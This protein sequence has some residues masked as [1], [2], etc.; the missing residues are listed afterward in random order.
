MSSP[1][2]SVCMP[3]SRPSAMFDEALSSVLAQTLGDFEVVVTDD[4]GGSLRATIEDAND[5]RVRYHPNA[6]R[7]GLSGNHCKAIDSARGRFVAIL[8][9]DDAWLPT[10][11]ET[12]ADVLQRG[13]QVGLCISASVDVAADGTVLRRKPNAMVPGVQRDPL[14]HLLDPR[15]PVMHPSATVWRRDALD[16]NHRP[17]ADLVVAD[18]TAFIDPVLAG[19]QVHYS[20]VPLVRYR[21]HDGQIGATQQCR[22]RDGLVKLWSGY[23]FADSRHEQLRR[24]LLARWHIARAGA[25]LRSGRVDAASMD[26]ASAARE[27]SSVQPLRRT[28]LRALCSAPWLIDPSRHALD[29]ARRLTAAAGTRRSHAHST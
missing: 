28:A 8:H 21:V 4:S 1:L 2:V 10:Y 19:W 20:A 14:S 29:S 13:P 3:A 17:W 6:Q 7:L 26:I 27:D 12:A 24:Q 11:L 18:M 25:L 5:S 16:S 23:R 15:F 22:H 9:D